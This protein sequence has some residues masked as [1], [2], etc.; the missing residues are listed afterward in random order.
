MKNPTAT[1]FGSSATVHI[2][3][4]P[5]NITIAFLLLAVFTLH[6]SK[7]KFDVGRLNNTGIYNW[8]LC[9]DVEDVYVVD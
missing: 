1:S 3:Q 7:I 5:F 4:G 9:K 2:F 6:G 8:S